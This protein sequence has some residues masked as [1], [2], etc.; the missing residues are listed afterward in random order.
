MTLSKLAPMIGLPNNN[1]YVKN[2][3]EPITF[4]KLA[5]IIGS[6]K[7]STRNP[8]IINGSTLVLPD[9]SGNDKNPPLYNLSAR[10]VFVY[11]ANHQ[12]IFLS[13]HSFFNRNITTNF[14]G[15]NFNSDVK[16]IGNARNDSN[17]NFENVK[18]ENLTLFGGPFQVVIKIH[19][20]TNPV[21]LPTSSSFNEYVGMSVPRG[22]DIVIKFSGNNSTY[23]QFDMMKK[24]DINTSQ[25]IKVGSADTSNSKAQILFQNVSTDNQGINYISAIMKSPQIRLKSYDDRGDVSEPSDEG[26]RALGFK[27]NSP[28]SA[29]IQIQKG[30][31]DITMNV[32]HVDNYDQDY[33]NWTRTR[34]MTYLKNDIQLTNDGKRIIPQ[35]GEQFLSAKLIAKIPGDISENAKDNGI[36]V[37]WRD[38][39]STVPN[40]M[41]AFGILAVAAIAV[42]SAWYKK[43][44]SE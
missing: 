31:G 22:F 23:A 16:N 43:V 39:F 18:I 27:I 38:V 8:I 34:F 32:D 30:I 37:P 14:T 36:V 7:I 29:S 20:G 35:G 25:T 21:Y 40:V 17:Y 11:T 12:K 41:L 10:D 9:S 19:N 28:D 15:N 4:S 2:I 6:L 42:A 26:T 24:N 13:S 33:Y 1:Q 44:K 3:P 5:G